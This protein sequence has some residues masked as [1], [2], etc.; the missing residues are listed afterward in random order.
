MENTSQHLD[1]V[2]RLAQQV[3]GLSHCLKDLC[4]GLK[5]AND[6]VDIELTQL[7]KRISALEAKGKGVRL[8]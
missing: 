1:A 2:I 5:D 7:N 8:L 4:D 3:K 6:F